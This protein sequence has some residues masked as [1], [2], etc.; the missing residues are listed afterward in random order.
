[1]MIRVV[2]SVAEL[3][4][5]KERNLFMENIIN[6]II[7]NPMYILAFGST[8]VLSVL[9]ALLAFRNRKNNKEEKKRNDTNKNEININIDLNGKEEDKNHSIKVEDNK[10]MNTHLKYMDKQEE[11]HD[12]PAIELDSDDKTKINNEYQKYDF[13]SEEYY[14]A[15]L[16]DVV[17]KKRGGD[18]VEFN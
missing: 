6:A 2:I 14:V 15:Y 5:F 18:S 8:G 4:L 10:N 9:L 17:E 12:S 1:M 7:E 13:S 16:T 11:K 3:K